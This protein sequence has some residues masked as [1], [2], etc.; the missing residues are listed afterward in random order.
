MGLD[1]VVITSL[2]L[3]SP[4]GINYLI[5]PGS[6]MTQTPDGTVMMQSILMEMCKVDTVSIG[7]GDLFTA[8]LLAWMHKQLKVSRW[9][10]K[11]LCRP[12]TMFCSRPSSVQK[13]RLWKD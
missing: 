6:Q 12:C 9:P 10:V 8:V 13:P 4:R 2:D 11:I 3:P 7:T 5:M 1:T